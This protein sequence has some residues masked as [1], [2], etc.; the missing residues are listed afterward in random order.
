M[1]KRVF[2][3]L[4]IILLII[5]I[6]AIAWVILS[7]KTNF[8]TGNVVQSKCKNITITPVEVT[9]STP[10][11]FSVILFRKGSSE[12][13][14]GVKL[15]FFDE[16]FNATSSADVKDNITAFQNISILVVNVNVPDPNKIIAMPY[17][18]DENGNEQFCE[19][20]LPF[21]F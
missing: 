3:A 4:L 20:S 14:G 13:I 8:F 7:G 5:I 9:N 10:G 19:T 15:I 2:I 21:E 6:S 18:L 17:F 11:N 12:E 16:K 1:R